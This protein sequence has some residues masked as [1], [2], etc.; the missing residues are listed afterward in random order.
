MSAVGEGS[1]CTFSL[2]S[3]GM[4]SIQFAIRMKKNSAVA[5][6]ITNGFGLPRLS[7]TCLVTCSMIVSHRS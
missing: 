2:S 4:I 6:G 3:V 5:S 7:V 1:R